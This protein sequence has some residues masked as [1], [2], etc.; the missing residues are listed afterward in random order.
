MAQIREIKKRI[1]AVHN[2]ERITNT[3]QMIATARFKAAMDRATATR[4]YSEQ[5]HTLVQELAVNA[6]DVTHPL[7]KSPDPSPERELVLVLTSDRGLCGAYN[8]NVLRTSNEYLRKIPET[9]VLEIVGKKGAGFFKFANIAISKHHTQ[10][11]DKPAYADV[12]VLANRFMSDFTAGKYDRITLAFM[13]FISTGR[14][15]AVI[16]QLLPLTPPV[17]E[18]ETGAASGQSSSETGVW[19]DFS[20]DAVSLLKELLPIT[21]K[22]ALYQAFNDAIVSEQVARMIAMKAATDNAGK[23]GKTLRRNFN[24]ARQSQITTELNEI[25]GGAAGLE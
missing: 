7:F 4:P 12:E 17:T 18:D 9:F 23:L 15:K 5:V 25:I 22:T 3:M 13:K 8:S 11:G 14:Q 10:F 24:R 6:G 1:K 20:P 16:E 2:I 21:V 19:Y